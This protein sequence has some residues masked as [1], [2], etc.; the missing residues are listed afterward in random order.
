VTSETFQSPPWPGGIVWGSGL[1]AL[2]IG[3]VA[4]TPAPWFIRL[5]AMMI[6]L[7]VVWW[8]AYILLPPPRLV[9]DDEGFVL[10]RRLA[11][12]RRVSW[13]EIE[14]FEIGRT[15]PLAVGWR[16]L[17]FVPAFVL[18]VVTS[19]GFIDGDITDTSRQAIGWRR[20]GKHSPTGWLVD[21]FG[22]S[23]NDLLIRLRARLDASR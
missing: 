20:R 12:P 7:L 15:P 4:L 16:I 19:A 11:R 2:S 10:H 5:G 22:L 8:T 23:Q 3:G 6:C 17:I 21:P 9:L 13:T 18:A 14:A 1:L